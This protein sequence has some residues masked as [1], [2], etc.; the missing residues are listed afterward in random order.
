MSNNKAA[1]A[2]PNFFIQLAID[3]S[4]LMIWFLLD[5]LR[6]S[7]TLVTNYIWTPLFDCADDLWKRPHPKCDVFF[8]LSLLGAGK[9]EKVCNPFCN[10]AADGLQA[11]SFVDLAYEALGSFFLGRV[12]YLFWCALFNDAPFVNAQFY[13]VKRNIEACT[14]IFL[15]KTPWHTYSTMRTVLW[16]GGKAA[17]S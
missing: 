3:D 9:R 15:S 11:F 14:E 6:Y 7:I 1:Q 2:K 4:L 13:E 5:T 16:F 8:S 12:K 17:T 10:G